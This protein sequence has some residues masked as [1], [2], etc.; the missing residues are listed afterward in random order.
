MIYPNSYMC[1][2]SAISLKNPFLAFSNCTFHYLALRTDPIP[3]YWI[4][5]C[6]KCV[7]RPNPIRFHALEE[8]LWSWKC[9]LQS[10]AP[11]A[12]ASWCQMHKSQS[13]TIDLTGQTPLGGDLT[14]R[15]TC[16]S[17]WQLF[18]CFIPLTFLL[19]LLRLYRL[20]LWLMNIHANRGGEEVFFLRCWGRSQRH[21]K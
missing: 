6:K 1:C 11:G 2:H 7:L 3:L 5:P 17:S 18:L 9:G 10:C 15:V 19:C 13:S 20:A 14:F 21:F 8:I 16:P 12:E 4:F